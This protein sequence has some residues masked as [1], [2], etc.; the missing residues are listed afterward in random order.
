LKT[1]SLLPSS[2]AERQSWPTTSSI[3]TANPRS[4]FNSHSV[5]FV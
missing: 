5:S 3:Y 4:N 1:V 2:Q